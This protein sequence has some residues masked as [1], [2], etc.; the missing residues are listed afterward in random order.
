[1]SV[2]VYT[3]RCYFIVF[4][5]VLCSHSRNAVSNRCMHVRNLSAA[6]STLFVCFFLRMTLQQFVFCWL[7]LFY[8][9]LYSFDLDCINLDWTGMHPLI[10]FYTNRFVSGSLFKARIRGLTLST[11]VL[12]VRNNTPLCLSSYKAGNANGQQTKQT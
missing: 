9:D 6:H 4:Y 8:V 5:F 12:A 7:K 2:S 3:V 10:F 11:C 1:M